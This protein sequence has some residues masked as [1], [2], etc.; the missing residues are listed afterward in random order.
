MPIHDRLGRRI[1]QEPPVLQLLSLLASDD[2]P[3]VLDANVESFF[4]TLALPHVGQ[5]TFSVEVARTSF[6]NGSWHS[7][8][9]NSKM[10]M[11]FRLCFLMSAAGHKPDASCL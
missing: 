10:G 2:D 3:F 7:G 11:F 6:S 8:Q 1:P 5:T 9:S 4:F